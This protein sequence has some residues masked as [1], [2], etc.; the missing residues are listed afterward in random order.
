MSTF[1]PDLFATCSGFVPVMF[2]TLFRLFQIWSG[3]VPGF[4]RCVL[5]LFLDC[6]LICKLFPICLTIVAHSRL[7]R[8]VSELVLDFVCG[9]VRTVFELCWTVS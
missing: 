5:G 7:F 6:V 1:V 9:L 2:L 8:S 4:S 3:L